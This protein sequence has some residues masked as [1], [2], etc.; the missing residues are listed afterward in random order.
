MGNRK[1]FINRKYGNKKYVED[2][3][4]FASMK[5]AY[6]Y[7]ELKALEKAGIIHDLRLQ[8]KYVLIPSQR[9]ECSEVYTRG[10][11]KGERKP[12]KLLESECAYYADF[13]YIENGQEIVE[14]T[15]GFRTKEFII[16]RKLMLW[17]HGIKIKET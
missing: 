14:D 6:R 9:E 16:K 15:K 11:H 2:G 3:I 10:K 5:E 13:V 8:V 4:T 7:H 12:G 17:V 1:N